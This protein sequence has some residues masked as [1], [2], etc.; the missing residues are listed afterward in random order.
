MCGAGAK[1]ESS[2]NIACY[3]TAGCKAYVMTADAKGRVK[4]YLKKCTAPLVPAR[5]AVSVN[6]SMLTG[7]SVACKPGQPVMALNTVSGAIKPTTQDAGGDGATA[8]GGGKASG[9]AGLKANKQQGRGG[10]ERRRLLGKRA[11]QE[12]VSAKES[13]DSVE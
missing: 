13:V 9:K 5:G 8:G 11:V 1:A 6:T 4:C 10:A 7:P 12:T 3:A 2:C